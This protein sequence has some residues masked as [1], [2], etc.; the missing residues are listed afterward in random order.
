MDN[1]MRNGNKRI[2]RHGLVIAVE[3]LNLSF[4]MERRY[5]YFP[6]C[7]NWSMVYNHSFAYRATRKKSPVSSNF[8]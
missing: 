3:N 6:F 8:F 1:E 7:L 2:L 5:Y 4:D